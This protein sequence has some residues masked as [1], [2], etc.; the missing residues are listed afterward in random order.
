MV[1]Q[2]DW[3]LTYWLHDI[4]ELYNL[5]IDPQELHNLAALT[6]YAAQ[7]DALL[8]TLFRWHRP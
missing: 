8:D 1:R 3:K 5:R 4:T 7:R 2:G 6:Q